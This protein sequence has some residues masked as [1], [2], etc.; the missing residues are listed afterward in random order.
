MNINEGQDQVNRGIKT[1]DVRTSN[2][3]VLAVL[4]VHVGGQRRF[5][6]SPL[7]SFRQP[8]A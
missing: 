6:F 8:L 4:Q 3:I 2:W 5:A 7:A 1:F